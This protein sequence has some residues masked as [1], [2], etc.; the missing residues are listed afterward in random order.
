M[1]FR[2]IGGYNNQIE[3][4]SYLNAVLASVIHNSRAFNTKLL[5]TYLQN[6]GVGFGG[7]DGGVAADS[8]FYT[9]G[10]LYALTSATGQSTITRHYI[11]YDSPFGC[12][13][14]VSDYFVTYT[15]TR[16]S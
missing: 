4:G 3:V 9:P 12:G 11:G 13:S 1:S 8:I 2:D 6:M 16:M 7:C 15:L 5:T 10:Q 14:R